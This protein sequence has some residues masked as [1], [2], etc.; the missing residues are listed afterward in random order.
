MLEEFFENG[1]TKTQFFPELEFSYSEEIKER[2]LISVISKKN[3]Y[4]LKKKKRFYEKNK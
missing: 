3:I 2:V 4:K 1:Q